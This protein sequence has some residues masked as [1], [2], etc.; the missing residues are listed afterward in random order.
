[1]PPSDRLEYQATG[2]CPVVRW[3]LVNR[4]PPWVQPSAVRPSTWTTIPRGCPLPAAN[5]VTSCPAAT[6]SRA[7]TAAAG[8][9][10]TTTIVPFRSAD[11]WFLAMG[12]QQVVDATEQ[13]GVE[14]V[15]PHHRHQVTEVRRRRRS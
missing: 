10:P 1:M 11:T 13:D 14:L 4:Y 7:A 9:L 12:G 15:R 6:S 8:P 3:R 5:I 2:S